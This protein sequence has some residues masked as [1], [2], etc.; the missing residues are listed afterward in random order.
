MTETACYDGVIEQWKINLALSR[1]RAFGFPSHEWPDLLQKLALHIAE[2]KF[3][4]DNGAKES[5]AL[6]ALINHQL[7]TMRRSHMREQKYLTRHRNKIR[8][9][10]Y[11]DRADLRLDVQLAIAALPATERAVCVRLLEGDKVNQ[12]ATELGCTWHAVRRVIRR[13]RTRFTNIG[14]DAWVRG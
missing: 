3:D 2:F 4:P 14:L 8:T 7:A 13:I 10:R 11:E 12:I 1:I 5:T 9:Q 6:Y